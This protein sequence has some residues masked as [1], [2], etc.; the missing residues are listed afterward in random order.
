MSFK[1]ELESLIANANSSLEDLETIIRRAQSRT[2][3]GDSLE[4]SD[5]DV[6]EIQ[7][8]LETVRQKIL[9]SL[10]EIRESYDHNQERLSNLEGEIKLGL[11][12]VRQCAFDYFS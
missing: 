11:E 5:G 4:A 9:T 3:Q 1:A 7:A 8:K 10:L 2:S 12:N 6:R